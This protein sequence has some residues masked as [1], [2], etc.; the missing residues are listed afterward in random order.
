MQF[1][2]LLHALLALPFAAASYAATASSAIVAAS[3]VK[4]YTTSS[5]IQLPLCKIATWE[6]GKRVKRGLDRWT[7]GFKVI[8]VNPQTFCGYW[9]RKAF[10]G[11]LYL[12]NVDC[13]RDDETEWDLEDGLI[14]RLDVSFPRGPAGTSS[15]RKCF[16][17]VTRRWTNDNGCWRPSTPELWKEDRYIGDGEPGR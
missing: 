12:S 2:I 8:G 17:D 13:H 1:S 16:R 11:C 14:W 15:F 6:R 7:I 4:N 5:E 3:A 10:S 9:K